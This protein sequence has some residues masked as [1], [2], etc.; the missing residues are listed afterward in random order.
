[1]LRFCED[2]CE[3]IHKIFYCN[4]KESVTSFLVNSIKFSMLR[5]ISIELRIWFDVV[6][7]YI[8]YAR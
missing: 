6:L 3:E 5:Y 7:V 1:M 2:C 8:F 4:L